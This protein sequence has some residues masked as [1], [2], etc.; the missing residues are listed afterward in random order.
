MLSKCANPA[1]S[2]AF[3][4]MREGKLFEIDNK[5]GQEFSS[6]GDS[7]AGQRKAIRKVEFFWLCGQCSAELTV[8]HDEKKGVAI[9]PLTTPFLVRRAAAS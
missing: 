9:I 3:R 5:S 8:V 1:C 2:T 4:Y 6:A 7:N